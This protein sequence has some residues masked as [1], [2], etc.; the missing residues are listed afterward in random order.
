MHQDNVEA[1]RCGAFTATDASTSRQV[2]G[3]PP[4]SRSQELTALSSAASDH[5]R[6]ASCVSDTPV[7][8]ADVSAPQSAMYASAS[9][10]A[11]TYAKQTGNI[12]S[13]GGTIPTAVDT[14]EPQF[15]GTVALEQRPQVSLKPG[16]A[17]GAV[18]RVRFAGA[19]DI[20]GSS[21]ELGSDEDPA[22][23]SPT[24][25][26]RLEDILLEG[27]EKAHRGA[28]IADAQR[29]RAAADPFCARTVVRQ[30]CI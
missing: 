17:A 5:G 2:T 1:S 7:A 22:L 16:R 6:N 24:R 28:L 12:S 26:Q 14:V 21:G 20:C 25:F 30:V 23:K 27:S 19:V 29:D 3:V 18:K 11:A 10:A 4:A 8:S 15:K 13:S 9:M